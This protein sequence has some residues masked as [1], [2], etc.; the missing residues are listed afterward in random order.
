MVYISDT[1]S[2]ARS[3]A[4]TY[5]KNDIKLSSKHYNTIPYIPSDQDMNNILDNEIIGTAENCIEKIN[6]LIEMLDV[7]ELILE[8]NFGGMPLNIAKKNLTHFSKL[9]LPHFS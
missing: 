7:E 3:A 2:L 4:S 5:I 1:N 8:F 9:V 6:Q